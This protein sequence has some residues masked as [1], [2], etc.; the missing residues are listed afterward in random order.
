MEEQELSALPVMTASNE[1]QLGASY[2][3]NCAHHTTPNN[4]IS[5]CSSDHFAQENL[6]SALTERLNNKIY[7]T[8]KK[9][10]VTLV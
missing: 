1:S 6:N 3:N 5:V 7:S 8:L 9:I 4:N 10:L 2:L